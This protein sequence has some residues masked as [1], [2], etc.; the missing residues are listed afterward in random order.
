MDEKKK[1]MRELRR[2]IREK[3]EENAELTR[4]LEELNVSV[5]ERLFIHEVN[6]KLLL[7][8]FST[9]KEKQTKKTNPKTTDSSN[10]IIQEKLKR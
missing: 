7:V 2:T 8:I 3:T 4:E 6:G 10:E 1:Q 9:K 5:N